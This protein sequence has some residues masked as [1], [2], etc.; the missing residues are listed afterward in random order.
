MRMVDMALP[1]LQPIP[2]DLLS[3]VKFD[4]TAVQRPIG[5]LRNRRNPQS[6]TNSQ[7]NR[8]DSI[9]N[10]SLF[11]FT[12]HHTGRLGGPCVLNA[13]SAA[14]RSEWQKKL[15]EALGLRNAVMD[16]N[17]LF[18]NETLS[19]DTFLVPS[20]AGA[21]IT[22][23]WTDTAT[24]GGRVTCSIPFSELIPLFIPCRRPVEH[25]TSYA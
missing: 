16:S 1:Q 10:S 25:I 4:D 2:L 21:Q 20:V 24:M 5:F 3:L 7:H 18:E 13:E 14:S 9:D 11:P 22:P 15:E 19:S 8:A 6:P 17:K 12:I 23:G